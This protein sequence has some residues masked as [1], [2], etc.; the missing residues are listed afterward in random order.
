MVNEGDLRRAPAVAPV[1]PAALTRGMRRPETARQLLAAC[2]GAP[3]A[4]DRHTCF[5]REPRDHRI[6]A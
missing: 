2:H 1:E 5:A 4:M 6:G 3:P